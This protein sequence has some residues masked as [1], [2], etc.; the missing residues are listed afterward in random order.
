M[1]Q[2]DSWAWAPGTTWPGFDV[3]NQANIG[4]NGNGL[5]IDPG[6]I[7]FI[8]Y[9]DANDDGAIYD[10]DTD[11]GQG[12]MGDTITVHGV[13]RTVHE[14]GRYS[15]G[16]MTVNGV[17][18]NVTM[19]VWVFTDG[20]YIVRINDADIPQGVHYSKVSALQ[21]G[22]WDGRDYN[23]T[24]IST[25]DDGFF[26]FVAGTLIRTPSGQRAVETL[27]PGDLVTTRDHG[28]QPVRWTAARNVS[29]RGLHAPIQI[30]PG[31]IG[32]R[33]LLV[34]SPQHRV[35][36]AGW[37][38]DL[39]FAVP[40]VLVPAVH[41]LDGRAV[42]QVPCDAVIYVHFL[43][44]RH[45]IVFAE[46]APCETFHPGD[47][48]YGRLDSAQRLELA[49]L[50]PDAPDAPAAFGATAYRCVTGREARVL[51]A[52][53]GRRPVWGDGPALPVSSGRRQ[54]SGCGGPMPCAGPSGA[55]G[56][57]P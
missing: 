3:A 30:A 2:T 11:D 43:C 41:L 47:M 34:L 48:A 5:V 56:L 9:N 22:T 15:D 44:D 27:R 18:Y 52:M 26:C 35:L 51:L 36:I 45:E 4:N 32:N 25:R 23:G 8:R 53:L 13:D 40:A 49:Q 54:R 39:L 17:T 12:A 1:Q 21:L 14:I 33:R 37:A 10:A 19:V 31:V 50:F 55:A 24:W 28:P 42:R 57:G 29:G 16:T 38:A 7:T 6:S 20:S 46:G